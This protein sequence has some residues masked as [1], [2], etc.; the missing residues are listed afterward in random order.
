[1]PYIY[2]LGMDGKPQMPTTRRRHVQRLLDTG[3]ARI[4]SHVPFTIQLLYKNDPVLQPVVLAE[5]PGR[6]NIGLA[7]LSLKGNLLFSAKVET[8]NREIAKLMDKRRQSRRAS[9]NGERKARQRLAK[10]FGTMLKAGLLMRKLPQYAANKFITCHVIRNTQARFSNRKRL[11]GWLTPSARHLVQTHINLV[12]LMQKYLP[13]T[14][15]GLEVNRFA[16]MQLEDPSISGVNF[17]NGPL[18]GFDDLHAAIRYLQDG[19]CLLC[20]KEIE[21]F[22]HIVPRSQHGSNTIGNIAGLCTKCHEKVHKDEKAGK[23]LKDKKKGLDKKYGALS[24]LNQAVPFICKELE[25]EFGKEH[26]YYCTGRET[27]V[28]RR[29][30]GYHK[31]KEN[32]LH[33]VDAWCIG[34]LSLDRIPEKAPDFTKVHTIMQ[35]RRQDRALI[36]AQTYRTYKLDGKTVAQNRKKRMD[37]KNDSLENWYLKQVQLHGQKEADRMRSC[38]KVKISQRRYNNPDRIFPGALFLYKGERHVISGTLTGGEYLRAVG[39][40]KTNYP[41]KECRIVKRNRGLVFID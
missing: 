4:A 10:K 22:H 15:I 31:T 6:T 13:V 37:Q 9:R 18:K 39:D 12:H 2:V 3:R 11:D 5:D 30:F 21:H 33:E 34:A 32:Q 41:V 27:A 28:L 16:F 26:V 14:D 23:R 29:S 17:Q 24:V 8:R 35:F 38:L 25:A 40:S 19:K 36:Q 20:K 7:A 1:M